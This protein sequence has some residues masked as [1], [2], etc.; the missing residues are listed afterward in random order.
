MQD[1][2]M[3]SKGKLTIEPEAHTV[4]LKVREIFIVPQ[5]RRHRPVAQNE[6]HLLLVEP[7]GTPDTGDETSAAPRQSA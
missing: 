1:F 6:A 7:S 3:I 5:V 2:F 4:T